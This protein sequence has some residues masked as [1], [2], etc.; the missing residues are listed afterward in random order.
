MK[1]NWFIVK[2]RISIFAFVRELNWFSCWDAI[3]FRY[4]VHLEALYRHYNQKRIIN[5]HVYRV[6]IAN[7]RVFDQLEL[8]ISRRY[9]MVWCGWKQF[10]YFQWTIEMEISQLYAK[11]FDC[12][13]RQMHCE[14]LPIVTADLSSRFYDNILFMFFPLVFVGMLKLCASVFLHASWL[15]EYFPKRHNFPAPFFSAFSAHK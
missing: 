14:R 12:Y 11:W 10:K 6:S 3:Y 13:R 8:C 7:V 4:E 9:I 5:I 15:C 1:I 2:R